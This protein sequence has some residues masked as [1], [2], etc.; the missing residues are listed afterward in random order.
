[1][2]YPI[3]QTTENYLLQAFSTA[4]D[5]VH[6]LSTTPKNHRVLNPTSA[7]RF[8]DGIR[9]VFTQIINVHD[10]LRYVAL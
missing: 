3:I 4:L 1:M 9:F 2:H 7:D 6:Q 8:G 5:Q 10:L